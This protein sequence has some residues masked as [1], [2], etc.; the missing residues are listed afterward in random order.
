MGAGARRGEGI[1][2]MGAILRES[3]VTR[4]MGP[5]S[6]TIAVSQEWKPQEKDIPGT[7][8]ARCDPSRGDSMVILNRVRER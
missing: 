5:G 4:E 6:D 3:D 7:S 1:A 8:R 2:T